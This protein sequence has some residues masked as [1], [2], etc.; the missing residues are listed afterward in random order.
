[1]NLE[2]IKTQFKKLKMFSSLDEIDEILL[3]NKKA[4]DLSWLS[5]LLESEIDARNEL[6]IQRH[7]SGVEL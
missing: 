2:T 4:V 3:K 6:A 5:A 7:T 1:M